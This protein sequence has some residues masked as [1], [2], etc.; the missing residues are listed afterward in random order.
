MR[1]ITEL[2]INHTSDQHPW[3]Q[4]ARNAQAG[5][6][7]ARL[8][9]L[10]RH[11]TRNTGDARIIFNDT[12]KSNWTWDPVAKAYYLAP[13]LF[14]SA[15]SE[16]RQSRRHRGGAQRHAISG[17]IWASTG[18]GSTPS[19]ISSS[20]KARAAKICR[21]RTPFIKKLRAALDANYPDR[22]LLAEANQWPEDVQSPIS[23]QGDECHM[24]FHF[25]LMPRIFMSL[26]LEDRHPIIDIMRQTPRDPQ[27]PANGRFSCAITTS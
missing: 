8:L 19:R 17:S 9:R 25:P 4:R 22:M 27:N 2:V 23:A 26:A 14:P 16:F 7:G 10:E 20:A 6:G 12:E 3:F 1:V 15:G 21:R 11:A 5:L 13:L 24:A 18:C